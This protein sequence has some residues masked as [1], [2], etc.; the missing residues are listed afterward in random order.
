MKKQAIF[1]ILWDVIFIVFAYIYSLTGQWIKEYV[2]RTMSIT[3][4][5]WLLPIMPMLMGG[6]KLGR[7]RRAYLVEYLQLIAQTFRST[8]E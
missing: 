7:Y 4:R 6:L 3:S 8:I 5:I 2:A 1:C